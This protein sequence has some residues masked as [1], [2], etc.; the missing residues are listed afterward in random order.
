MLL[1]LLLHL[2]RTCSSS[3]ISKFS[4]FSTYFSS[5]L[6]PPPPLPPHLTNAP[7]LHLF[8][9]PLLF[10]SV[11]SY[12]YSSARPPPVAPTSLLLFSPAPPPPLMLLFF[13]ISSLPSTKSFAA[14]LSAS[15]PF[16][17]RCAG[18]SSRQIVSLTCSKRYRAMYPQPPTL[19]LCLEL[20]F[21]PIGLH[22]WSYGT[23][24][25]VRA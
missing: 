14:E 8:P 25:S 12:F 20:G 15:Q 7:I 16:E 22:I 10:L 17:Q 1:S 19:T 3:Y 23:V 13:T 24:T 18:R 11:S 21:A 2:F 5:P 6:H 9:L 4:S